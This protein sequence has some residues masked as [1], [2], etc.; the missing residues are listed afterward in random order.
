MQKALLQKLFFVGYAGLQGCLGTRYS[1]RECLEELTRI[2]QVWDDNFS[3]VLNVDARGGNGRALQ[4]KHCASNFSASNPAAATKG[5]LKRC[6]KY[7]IL[8]QPRRSPKA[9]AGSKSSRT[10]HNDEDLPVKK[11]LAKVLAVQQ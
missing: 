8:Q 5:H 6:S 10:L 3:V 2:K 1:P 4:C 7:I 11:K 9:H